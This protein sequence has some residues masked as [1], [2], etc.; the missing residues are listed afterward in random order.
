LSRSPLVGQVNRQMQVLYESIADP[1]QCVRDRRW[2]NLCSWA[3]LALK[4]CHRLLECPQ[5]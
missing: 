1:A 2:Q 3:A 4:R 5:F